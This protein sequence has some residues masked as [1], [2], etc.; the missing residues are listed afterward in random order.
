VLHVHFTLYLQMLYFLTEE[1]A[2]IDA[3]PENQLGWEAYMDSIQHL[4]PGLKCETCGKYPRALVCPV[5]AAQNLLMEY[6]EAEAK[7]MRARREERRAIAAGTPNEFD[8]STAVMLATSDGD[9]LASDWYRQPPTPRQTPAP[10]PNLWANPS[11]AVNMEE[12]LSTELND[13]LE[14]DDYDQDIYDYVYAQDTTLRYDIWTGEGMFGSYGKPYYMS[15]DDMLKYGIT[16][17]DRCESMHRQQDA[18]RAD[19]WASAVSTSSP[20]DCSL[21]PRLLELKHV[22]FVAVHH[23]IMLHEDD[24][25]LE[26]H[27]AC[28]Q[29]SFELCNHHD[30]LKNTELAIEMVDVIR[31]PAN[32]ARQ[33]S[34][35]QLANTI[36]LFHTRAPM[37]RWE[38][39]FIS[40]SVCKW[41]GYIAEF[42]P[43]LLDE[44]IY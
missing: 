17:R 37:T 32:V 29:C 33:E 10:N 1:Q 15:R 4:M 13:D 5:V 41:L 43:M 21:S 20:G 34:V 11:N 14:Y 26:I 38:K 24:L 30:N 2:L 44:C 7:R 31:N 40:H 16:E 19:I 36:V 23:Y 22:V 3:M 28:T 9:T 6:R 35:C 8:P 42:H 27:N 12:Y 18:F 39:A 25:T